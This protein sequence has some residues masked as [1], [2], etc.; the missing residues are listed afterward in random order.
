VR[1]SEPG[2][3]GN[4]AIVLISQSLRILLTGSRA[5]RTVLGLFHGQ[6]RPR[7]EMGGVIDK[8]LDGRD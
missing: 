7:P 1:R 8:P 4:F 6:A 5:I 3:G 2:S